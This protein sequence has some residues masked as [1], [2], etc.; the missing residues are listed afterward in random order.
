MHKLIP[1]LI[2]F[3]ICEDSLTTIGAKQLT[4]GKSMNVNLKE[5]E[6]SRIKRGIVTYILCDLTNIDM[7]CDYDVELNN[8]A[9]LEYVVSV[10]AT[11]MFVAIAMIFI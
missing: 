4:F 6:K 2:L 1:L 9:S 11:A 3:V 5:N 8:C 7:E 10:I